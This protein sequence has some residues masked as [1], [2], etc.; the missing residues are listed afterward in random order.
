MILCKHDFRIEWSPRGPARSVF[1]L[2][3]CI[4]RLYFCISADYWA[5]QDF[6]ASIRPLGHT[7]F[8][9]IYTSL[10]PYRIFMHLY[11]PWAIQDFHASIRPLGYTGFSCIYMSLGPYMIF[12][13][14]YVPWAIQD[15]H[16]SIRPLGNIGFTCI[17]TSLGSFRRPIWSDMFCKFHPLRG[18][19]N[20]GRGI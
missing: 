2:I 6:H 10:G 18:L 12:M 1:G 17:Y 7:G 15:F 19:Y 3:S 11:A 8:S 13:H 20:R 9:C 5:I 4:S 14:L 16:S